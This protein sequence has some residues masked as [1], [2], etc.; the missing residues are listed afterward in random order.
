MQYNQD[1]PRI[2]TALAEWGACMVY[3]CL[4]KREKF[5]RL[6]FWLVSLAVLA[7]QAAF[8][9]LT[10]GLPVA[11]WLSCMACLLYTSPSPRDTR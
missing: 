3:L 5:R 6:S 4:I 11:F 9:E 8:L 10:G 1:I 7:V 2:C